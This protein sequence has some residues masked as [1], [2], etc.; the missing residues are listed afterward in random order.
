MIECYTDFDLH[1]QF[2]CFF[3]NERLCADRSND[4]KRDCPTC[5]LAKY[6]HWRKLHSICFPHCKLQQSEVTKKQLLTLNNIEINKIN[7]KRKMNLTLMICYTEIKV[8]N[9]NIIILRILFF[10]SFWSI[11]RTPFLSVWYQIAQR[12]KTQC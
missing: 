8:L 12:I 9:V 2:A 6:Y 10:S 4:E 1:L 7:K 3:R 5:S 11:I